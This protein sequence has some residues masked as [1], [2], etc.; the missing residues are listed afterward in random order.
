M[1]K[2]KVKRSV[3]LRHNKRLKEEDAKLNPS[4][5]GRA[6][7]DDVDD[8]DV[9]EGYF[10]EEGESRNNKKSNQWDEQE[11]DYEL[12]PR[13]LGKH[14]GDTEEGLIEGL[15]IRKADER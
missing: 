4:I 10:E 1:G 7:N 11:Q 14:Y 2:R 6:N 13:V 8:V 5:F 9:E 15:P 12:K 3:E